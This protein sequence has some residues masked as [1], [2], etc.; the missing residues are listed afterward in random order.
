[1]NTTSNNNA[2]TTSLDNT[3][4]SKEP[5]D[6][7]GYLEAFVIFFFGIPIFGWIILFCT[8]VLGMPLPSW[9]RPPTPEI[10]ELVKQGVM[11][12]VKMG[13]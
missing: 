3:D 9:Q 4:S 7:R 1:M 6:W 2:T 5:I 13:M 12:P 11:R 10:E 8:Q